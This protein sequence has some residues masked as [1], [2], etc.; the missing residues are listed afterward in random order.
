MEIPKTSHINDNQPARLLKN[1]TNKEPNNSHASNSKD[2]TI[3]ISNNAQ[4][5]H[6]FNTFIN[7]LEQPSNRKSDLEIMELEGNSSVNDNHSSAWKM[8]DLALGEMFFGKAL[9]DEWASKGLHINEDTIRKAGQVFNEAFKMYVNSPD[10]GH[11]GPSLDRHGLVANNQEVPAWF[12]DEHIEW[13]SYM[14]SDARKAFNAGSYY[15][16]P[17]KNS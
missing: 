8:G 5:A 15:H 16:L 2:D 17:S 9:L 11:I 14:P 12:N 13:L 3:S 1:H 10:R 6:I 7:Q 4:Y